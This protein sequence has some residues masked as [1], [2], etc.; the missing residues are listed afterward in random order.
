M[1]NLVLN[2]PAFNKIKNSKIISFMVDDLFEKANFGF[3]DFSKM[4][5]EAAE[6]L[7]Q[8]ER[9]NDSSISEK[10]FND[11][12]AKNKGD[13][14]EI[15]VMFTLQFFE[16]NSKYGIIQESYK[17]IPD[18]DDCGLD[19]H[20]IQFSSNKRIFGQIK[21]RE[22]HPNNEAFGR[23]EFYKLLG[24]AVDTFDFDK[25]NDFLFLV[26][27]QSTNYALKTKLKQ[28]LGFA[29]DNVDFKHAFIKILDEN[30]F[31]DLIDYNNRKFWEEFKNQF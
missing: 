24:I 23:N 7:A 13:I 22:N 17:Q 18:E 1:K 10:E 14:F 9:E 26:T 2:H 12:V 20:G 8:L 31:Q 30:V 4:I 29:H 27:N 28:D 6:D 19:F 21:F 25:K 15:F 16:S 3:I 5:S 11:K